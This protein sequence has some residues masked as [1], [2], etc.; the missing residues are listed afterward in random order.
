MATRVIYNPRVPAEATVARGSQSKAAHGRKGLFACGPGLKGKRFSLWVRRARASRPGE[1]VRGPAQC[2]LHG[3]SSGCYW[4]RDPI[5]GLAG[6]CCTECAN[7]GVACRG[8]PRP[9]AMKIMCMIELPLLCAMWLFCLCF[10]LGESTIVII[11]R[12]FLLILTTIILGL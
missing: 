11:E 10:K 7:F 12:V 6:C 9:C 2:R 8:L 4:E 5:G 3:S 1:C